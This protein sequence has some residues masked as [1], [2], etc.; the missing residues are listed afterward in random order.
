MTLAEDQ[1]DV[2]IVGGG[3]VGL[4]ASLL[5]SQLGV[6][7]V[8]F[9][10]H[11]GTSIYPRAV[12]LNQRTME[13]FRGLGL[14]DAVIA[15]AAP[16]LCHEL[17]AWYTSFAGRTPLHG[18]MLASR[19]GWGGGDYV[20][21]YASASPCTYRQLAQIRLEPLLR[22]HAERSA[23]AGI[24]FGAEVVDLREDDSGVTVAVSSTDGHREVWAKYVIGADGGRT[25]GTLLGIGDT[26]P[27][28]LVDMVSVHFTADLSAHHDPRVMISWF[29]N[30]DLGGSVGTGFL[31]PIGPWDAAGHSREWVF[32][33]AMG[34]DDPE[35]FDQEAARTRLIATLGVDVLAFTVH[36]VSHWYI[37]SMV[38]D[39]FQSRRCFLVGDAAHRVPPW[40]ALGMNTGMQDVRNLCWKVALA[41]AEPMAG[42]MLDSYEPER[43][44][45]A[46]SVARTA[47]ESFHNAVGVIDAALG[48]RADQTPET[49][50][51][52][53]A[54]LWENSID[55]AARRAAMDKAVRSLDLEFHAHGAE[56]GFSYTAGAV[57]PHP[58]AD[59]LEADLTTYR[60]TTAPGHHIP[61]FWART[62]HGAT[63]AMVDL[64]RPGRFLLI[65]DE[66]A[67]TWRAAL[68][69]S[70]HPVTSRIDV[71]V[72]RGASTSPDH[73]MS[74]G[75][76]REA[77]AS[78]A[79]LVRPDS[80]VA[81]RWR[82]LPIDPAA[83]LCAALAQLTAPHRSGAAERA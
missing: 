51:H 48:L 20:A 63:V 67:D 4:T 81:W 55:G 45:V 58:D 66:H 38:A 70:T 40:G 76:V 80:I 65:V 62:G 19:H 60:A 49:G 7:H 32:V 61:H 56:C 3:P 1:V 54:M 27:S 79:L 39:A 6:P 22:A 10:R 43:R 14:E 33:F 2:V 73:A 59:L 35:R 30:P 77:D 64:L 52:N 57:Q 21:E 25:V 36:S 24:E 47:L 23:V 11:E 16:L 78:G 8:L 46:Q 31:Y 37:R 29:I 53:I 17:T 44:P 26:G 82:T 74:W 83:E 13:V 42:P 71:E 28:N 15:E 18:R 12:S 41:L 9:E 34:A 50:W 72:V 75:E 68:D 5:L 69:A